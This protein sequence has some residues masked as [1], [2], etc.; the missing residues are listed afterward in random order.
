MVSA[1]NKCYYTA[2]PNQLQGGNFHAA[3][4]LSGIILLQKQIFIYTFQVD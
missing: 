4:N 2:C 3:V 1:S